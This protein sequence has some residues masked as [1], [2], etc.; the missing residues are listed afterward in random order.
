MKTTK[1]LY[2]VFTSLFAF[3]MFGS[4]I[5][6]ILSSEVAVQGMHHILGYTPAQWGFMAMPLVLLLLAY[7]WFHLR[8]Q[9]ALAV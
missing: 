9:A 8:E 3:M 7:R 4:A 6:D 5:P 2:W 1:T